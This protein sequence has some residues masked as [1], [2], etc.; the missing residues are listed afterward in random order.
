MCVLWAKW[1]FNEDYVLSK[2]LVNNIISPKIT[3]YQ[4]SFFPLVYHIPNS[5]WWYPKSDKFFDG[6]VWCLDSP[7]Q[8]FPYETV[9]LC[10][11]C[12]RR[13]SFWTDLKKTES[14]GFPCP[15][16]CSLCFILLQHNRFWW[17]RLS[18]FRQVTLIQAE[19]K[20]LLICRTDII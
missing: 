10:T 17:S 3:K 4:A 6:L 19:Y 13:N 9:L 15:S 14:M 8:C 5:I 11:A 16:S 7:H 12:A 18:F 20:V 1:F 2:V